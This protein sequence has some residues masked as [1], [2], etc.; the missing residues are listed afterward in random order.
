MGCENTGRVVQAETR[1]RTGLPDIPLWWRGEERRGEEGLTRSPLSEGGTQPR[2]ERRTRLEVRGGRPTPHHT[3]LHH[4]PHRTRPP[5][6][7]LLTAQDRRHT[8]ANSQALSHCHLIVKI[9]LHNLHHLQLLQQQPH[10]VQQ[11]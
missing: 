6:T 11:P 9:Y 8:A 7:T 10:N 1:W 5:H 4:T 2:Q 3:T